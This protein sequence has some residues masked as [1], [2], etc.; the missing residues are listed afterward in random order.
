M[1]RA[2][3]RRA[4]AAAFRERERRLAKIRKSV[5]RLVAQLPGGM[6]LWERRGARFVLPAIPPGA[7]RVA[8]FVLE[9]T[10]SPWLYSEC[11]FCHARLQFVRDWGD[12]DPLTVIHAPDCVAHHAQH[13]RTKTKGDQHRAG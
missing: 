13:H 2:E 9:T 11:E 8:R 1:S 6:E 5:P 3:A 4:R 10:R 7:D 12:R